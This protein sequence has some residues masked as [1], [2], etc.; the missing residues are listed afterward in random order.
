MSSRSSLNQFQ[1]VLRVKSWQIKWLICAV[2]HQKEQDFRT[3]GQFGRH[4]S[5]KDVPWRNMRYLQC[6]F[7]CCYLLKLEMVQEHQVG[8]FQLYLSQEALYQSRTYGQYGTIFICPQRQCHCKNCK[9][10]SY[11]FIWQ[12]LC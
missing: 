7:M 9:F 8:K 1:S 11:N 6:N 2:F 3:S 10:L 5:L 12:L 4:V